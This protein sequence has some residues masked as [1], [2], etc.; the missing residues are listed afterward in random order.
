MI[1][2]IKAIN[3]LKITLNMRYTKNKS[4][5][6]EDYLNEKIEIITDI[7]RKRIPD[8]I[9]IIMG[10]GFGKGEGSVVVENKEVILINDFDMY[11]V[12]KKEYDED[13][14]NDI[15]QEASRKIGK[16]GISSFVKFNKN[17]PLL[18][19]FFYIDLKVIPIDYLKKLPPMVKFYDLRNSSKIVYGKNT[20]NKIP[21]FKPDDLPIAEG[22]R[23]LLNR[24][25][26]LVQHFYSS[27][28]TKNV[29]ENDHQ[30]FLL[31]TI[32]T[33]TDACGALLIL[34]KKYE[35]TYSKRLNIFKKRYSEDFPELKKLIPEYVEKLKEFTELKLNFNLN[36]Y[37]GKDLELWK[38]SRN[39]IGI[40]TKYFFKKFLNKEVNNYYDLSKA[41]EE[42]AVKYYNPYIR[43]ILK[44]KFKLDTNNKYILSLGSI[45]AHIYMNF[46]YFNRM[47]ECH[48]KLYIRGLFRI[49]P[50]ELTFFSALPLILYSLNDDGRVNLKMLEEGKR[51][52]QKV[53]PVNV[54]HNG[55]DLRYW[56]D[57]ANV[58]SNAYVLFAFLKLK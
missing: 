34:S 25:S 10:G 42:S 37:K 50:P 9:G 13:I 40:A 24:M 6:V 54:K 8:T 58:Y 35:A 5:R 53:Y 43:Y 38:Q 26:H 11:V 12:A 16:K 51:K 4:K 21:D 48:N 15:A 1:N 7:I 20:L 31:H 32:K 33:Y 22:A 46:L 18:K 36:A 39:Y 29:K 3:F 47:R 14:I 27:F 19:D 45:A 56:E 2:I 57:I 52:L 55:S 41:I 44:R 17:R 28:L 30:I 49:K 23:L